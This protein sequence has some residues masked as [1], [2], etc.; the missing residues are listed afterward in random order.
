MEL[1]G[2]EAIV[3]I[4]RTV[5]KKRVKKSY[6]IKEIDDKLR[7][8]RTRKEAKLLSQAKRAGVN[9]PLVI[10]TGKDFIEMSKIEGKVLRDCFDTLENWQEVC[11][12]IGEGIAKLHAN[13]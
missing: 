5:L 10:E 9:T 8:E 12:R 13:D 6:R 2:A 4:S 1:N 3:R 7:F 11:G